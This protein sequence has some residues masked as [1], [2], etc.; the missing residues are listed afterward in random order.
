MDKVSLS[1]RASMA[2]EKWEVEE[3]HEGERPRSKN[4]REYL[5][6]SY[7]TTL[8]AEKGWVGEEVEAC[9]HMY[10]VS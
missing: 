6:P 10:S 3:D 4:K 8:V 7:D 2:G 5:L 9:H 1:E